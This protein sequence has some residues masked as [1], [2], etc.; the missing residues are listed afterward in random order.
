MDEEAGQC[1]HWFF[2]EE[3]HVPDP[4]QI[5][6]SL[7]SEQKRMGSQIDRL[8]GQLVAMR[9]EMDKMK[10]TKSTFTKP[11]SQAG[12]GPSNDKK[13]KAAPEPVAVA[14]PSKHKKRK[15]DKKQDPKEKGR[16]SD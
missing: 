12:P 16:L 14:G 1:G 3:N 10:G 11:T 15:Q 5:L 4:S 7:K 8:S 13:R 6:E 9:G 2:S